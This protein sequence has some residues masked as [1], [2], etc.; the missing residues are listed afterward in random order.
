VRSLSLRPNDSLTIPRMALSIDFRGI[1]RPIILTVL[2]MA[3]NQ[4]RIISDPPPRTHQTDK[5]PSP[6]TDALPGNLFGVWQGHG[7]VPSRH[8]SCDL[9]VELKQPEPS[10]YMAYT[11]FSCVNIDPMTIPIRKV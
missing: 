9:R 3:Y 4:H 6:N 2:R 7:R 11:R 1:T 5:P 8:S 10:R